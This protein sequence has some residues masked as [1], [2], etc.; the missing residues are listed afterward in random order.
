M[1]ADQR[2][3]WRNLFEYYAFGSHG[4]P[5]AHLGPEDRGSLGD[6]DDALVARIRKAIGLPPA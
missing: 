6:L 4:D 5:V 1:P 3:V 2:T